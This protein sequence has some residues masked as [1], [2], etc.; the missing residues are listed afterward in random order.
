V[1]PKLTYQLEDGVVLSRQDIPDF[2]FWFYFKSSVHSN[3]WTQTLRV[4]SNP[5]G[6]LLHNCTWN[7]SSWQTCHFSLLQTWPLQHGLYFV[8][9]EPTACYLVRVFFRGAALELKPG[10]LH[11]LGKHSTTQL[12][13]QLLV[14][15]K[16]SKCKRLP[17]P[18]DPWPAGSAEPGLILQRSTGRGV[19]MDTLLLPM[20]SWS[21]LPPPAFMD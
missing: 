6:F 4:G 21:V 19:D 1:L 14:A 16:I 15:L 10:T 2:D 18:N 17:S 9:L 20:V 11:L 13:L 5:A 8:Q 7:S 3:I 12:H